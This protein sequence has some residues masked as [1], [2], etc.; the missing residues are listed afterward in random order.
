MLNRRTFLSLPI[1]S[2]P[3]FGKESKSPNGLGKYVKHTV[4]CQ[5]DLEREFQGCECHKKGPYRRFVSFPIECILSIE[6]ERGKEEYHAWN[7]IPEDIGAIGNMSY[8]E[9]S[10]YATKEKSGLHSPYTDMDVKFYKILDYNFQLASIWF[11]E[12]R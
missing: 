2:V 5:Y 10:K 12:Q 1:F 8:K 11:G 6:F 9:L 3:F 4:Q 7:V